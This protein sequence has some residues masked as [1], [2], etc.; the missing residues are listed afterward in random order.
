MDPTTGTGSGCE[1]TK[2]IP[3]WMMRKTLMQCMEAGHFGK[4]AMDMMR[5]EHAL[6]CGSSPAE[7]GQQDGGAELLGVPQEFRGG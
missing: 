6:P 3:S 2:K 5:L 1:V 7:S 4:D